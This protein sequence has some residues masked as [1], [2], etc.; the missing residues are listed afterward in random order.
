MVDWQ[1]VY[2]SQFADGTLVCQQLGAQGAQTSITDSARDDPWEFA[3]SIPLVPVSPWQNS[4]S[5]T[6]LQ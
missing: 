3:V 5:Q 4:T 2:E 6:H 1:S